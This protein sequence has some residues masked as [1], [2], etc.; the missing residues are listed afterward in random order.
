MCKTLCGTLLLLA[1]FVLFLNFSH[2]TAK[3]IMGGRENSKGN[4]IEKNKLN[5]VYDVFEFLYNK[6][7]DDTYLSN[8]KNQSFTMHIWEIGEIE[9]VKTTCKKTESDFHQCHLEREFYTIKRISKVTMYYIWLPGRVRCR[10]FRSNLGKCPFQ[11]QT[12]ELKR[13][14]C[15]FQLYPHYYKQNVNAVRFY[16]YAE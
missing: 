13:E 11:E 4:F 1:I 2:A 5:D 3:T 12:E 6:Y 14:I 8:I 16:C 10:K 15:Y 9:M 7:N